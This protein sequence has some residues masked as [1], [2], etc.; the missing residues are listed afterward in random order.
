MDMDSY[1]YPMK[2][3]VGERGQVTIPKEIRDRFGIRPG[4]VV[5]FEEREGTIVLRKRSIREDVESVSGTLDLGGRTTDEII[6]EM[7]GPID[8]P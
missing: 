3:V 6:E 7:R 1:S 4:E 2:S 8:L 5:V